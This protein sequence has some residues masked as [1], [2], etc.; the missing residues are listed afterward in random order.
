MLPR[1]RQTGAVNMLLVS[2]AG[3]AA[4]AITANN[5]NSIRGSQE[6][7]LSLQANVQAA[8]EAWRGTEVVAAYLRTAGT[9]NPNGTT[10][11]PEGAGFS[12]TITGVEQWNGSGWVAVTG[13]SALGSTTAETRYRIHANISG[14]GAAGTSKMLEAY[15]ELKLPA[16]TQNNPQQPAQ[17]SSGQYRLPDTVSIHSNLTLQGGIN[18]EGD[19]NANFMVDGNATLSGSVTGLDQL[20]ATGDI[21]IQSGITVNYVCSNK[22]VTISQGATV[23][24]IVAIGQV[25]LNSGN[26]KVETVLSNGKVLFS[27]GGTKVTNVNATGDVSI[28]GGAGQITGTLNTEGNVT[29]DNTFPANAINANGNVTYRPN[30]SATIRSRG[31]VTLSAGDSKVANVYALGWVSLLSSWGAG[32]S[33]I[34]R[35]G[36][37]VNWKQGN[38]IGD[39]IVKGQILGTAPKAWEPLVN[40]FRD[41]NLTLEISPVSIPIIEPVVMERPVIDANTF[42]DSANYVFYYSGGQKRVTVRNVEEIDD[43]DY[44]IADYPVQWNVP[45]LKENNKDYLCKAVNASGLC[46]E[47]A[48]PYRTLCQGWSRSN[49]CFTYSGGQWTFNGESM[50]PGAAWFDGSLKLANGKF[51]NTFLATGHIDITQGSVRVYSPNYAGYAGVC[52]DSKG[53][54]ISTDYRLSGL[55]PKNSCDGSTYIASPLGNVALLAG[56]F[57]SSGVF[58]G[59]NINLSASNEIYGTIMAGGVLK[60][61]GSTKMYGALLVANTPKTGSTQIQGGVNILLS[62][63][64]DTYDPDVIPCVGDD[65]DSDVDENQDDSNEAAAGSNGLVTRLWTRYAD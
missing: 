58:S 44:I 10:L 17:T 50:A 1:K 11:N 41:P 43:G 3:L 8:G 12:A 42:K 52:T 32:I 39:G 24:R 28:S 57:N 60:T 25:N 56:S 4:L 65:C 19:S 21:T 45:A 40:V 55:K 64:P 35:G 48:V 27:G 47:P 34:L 59:G 9:S 18:I 37:T 38:T 63:L 5:L 16:L 54:G 22:S 36:S 7:N 53:F 46:V 2:L 6:G 23:D 61:S 29:W 62:D 51:I 30:S 26:A 31:N 15:Y 20:C 33:N 49:N 13:N 14:Q